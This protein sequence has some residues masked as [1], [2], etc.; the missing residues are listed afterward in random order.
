MVPI[1]SLTSVNGVPLTRLLPADQLG[2][3]V[4]RT[5]D[6]GA[7]IVNLLK[8]GS[9]YYAPTASQAELVRAVANDEHRLL[10]VTAALQGEY[11]LK[12]VYLGVPTRIGRQGV[13]HVFEVELTTAERAAFEASAAAVQQDLALL[14]S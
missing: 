14:P 13:E 9:A 3:I 10:P 2:K 4:Q 12:D 8:A 6:G 5:K 1:L 7:E 11:G